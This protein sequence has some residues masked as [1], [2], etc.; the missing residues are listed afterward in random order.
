[1]NGTIGEIRGFGGNFAPRSWALCQGQLLAISTNTAL[2]SII[3]TTYGG[4]GRTTFALPDLRGRIP[5]G[6]GTGPGLTTRKLGERSGSET[7]TITANQMAVHTHFVTGGGVTGVSG[8]ATAT[9][10]VNNTSGSSSNPADNYLGFESGS[11]G[12]YES[13]PDGS[14]LNSRAVTLD[15]SGL[16]VQVS[17]LSLS[18]TGGGQPVN[19]M[20]PFLTVNWIVCMQGIYPSRN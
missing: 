4:D 5:I 6:E 3:G 11:I 10:H 15:T 16:A 17:G 20:K 1:M 8:S 19:N 13:T 9:M 12:L 2:F 18:P 7:N 14:T